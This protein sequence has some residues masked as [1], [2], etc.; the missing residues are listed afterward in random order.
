[1]QMCNISGAISLFPNIKGAIAPLAPVLNTSLKL[2]QVRFL[3]SKYSLKPLKF[4][5]PRET[6]T[7]KAEQFC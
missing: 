1:M 2:A 5:L 7:K 4:S 6:D 3:C